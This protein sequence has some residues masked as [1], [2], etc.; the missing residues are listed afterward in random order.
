L[1][2]AARM[3]DRHLLPKPRA[4]L[5]ALAVNAA[6]LLVAFRFFIVP[7]GARYAAQGQD[8]ALTQRLLA[9][10]ERNLDAYEANLGALQADAPP[11]PGGRF[12]ELDRLLRRHGVAEESFEILITEELPPPAEG[13]L[14]VVRARLVCAGA[15]ENLLA[16][17]EALTYI[18]YPDG[19]A[20]VLERLTVRGAALPGEGPAQAEMD[21]AFT[22]YEPPAS[23]PPAAP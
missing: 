20:C 4:V 15:Y 23:E 10:R 9:V 17:A 22:F 2:G 12:A 18:P 19:T 21:L 8:L 13:R 3:N 16:C 1:E 6:L 11:P 5:M 14:T 7:A